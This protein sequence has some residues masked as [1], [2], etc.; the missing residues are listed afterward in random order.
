MADAEHT[1]EELLEENERL[2]TRLDEQARIAAYHSDRFDFLVGALP[3]Q[4]WTARPDGALDYVNPR[5]VEYFGLSAERIIGEGW[6]AVIHPD[7][8]PEVTARWG[9]ALA[10]GQPHDVELRLRRA[11][12]AFR[13]HL[14]RA[15]PQ[16]NAAGEIVRWFGTN[17]DVSD[18]KDA[19][20]RLAASEQ[21]YRVLGTAAHDGMWFWDLTS[22]RV[23]WSGRLFELLGLPDGEW[24]V[25]FEPFLAL[26]HPDDLPR[27]RA[28]LADHLAHGTP[29]NLEFR[30]RHRDGHYLHCG[31][32]GQAERDTGGR[33]IR[34][35]G[36]VSDI[37]RR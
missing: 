1:R 12:G 33:P 8:L 32:R 19:L 28:A 25:S 16:R 24:G 13:W 11:D 36:G 27:M 23:E 35:A 4:M 37:T 34:M 30:L 22:D 31:T 3:D 7:D 6:L 29:Y 14:A 2:R 9:R 21:R 18:L 5:M 26:V 20:A 15:L 17:T 10:S